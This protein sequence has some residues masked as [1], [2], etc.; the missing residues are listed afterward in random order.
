[1][2][3]PWHRIG[4]QGI[5]MDVPEG[6]DI[7]AVSGGGGSNDGYLR[8]EDS[9]LPRVEMK[10][11]YEDGFV[12]LEK[13]VDNYLNKLEKGQKGQ[14]PPEVNRD[15]RVVSK[16]K[17]QKKALQCFTWYNAEEE[18]RG[19]GAAWFCPDCRHAVIAQVTSRTDEEGEDLAER[20]ITSIQDH[21][22]DNWIRWA[23]WGF[24]AQTPERFKMTGSELMAGH[25]QLSFK[26][27]AA[28][29]DARSIMLQNVAR[30]EELTLG[31]WGMANVLL[32]DMTLEEWAKEEMG[33]G[34]KRMD[35]E[36]T[37]T[38]IHGHEGLAIKGQKL[39]PWQKAARIICRFAEVPFADRIRGRIWHCPQSNSLH[40][41][42]MMIDRTNED[43]PDEVAERFVCHHEDEEQ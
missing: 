9:Q 7:A 4:W 32:K 24:E 21:P 14:E 26:R 16:R 5:E 39:W 11:A 36:I 30:P 19:Y 40:M 1:M 43:L 27:D 33:K 15:A 3:G 34:L 38:E 28:A 12:D 35:P 13:M 31:R 37:E 20:V 41:V 42:Q 2:N 29:D 17:M 6:W 22:G 8:I 23:T 25:I 18:L 10:W